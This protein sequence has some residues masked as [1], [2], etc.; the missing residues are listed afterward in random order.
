MLLSADNL[1]NPIKLSPPQNIDEQC[2]EHVALLNLV[3]I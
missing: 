1:P 2:H 3:Y